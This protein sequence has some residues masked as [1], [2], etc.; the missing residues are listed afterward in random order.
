MTFLSGSGPDSG[1]PRRDI[2]PYI[3]IRGRYVIQMLLCAGFCLG[4][5]VAHLQFER[6]GANKDTHAKIE[7][8]IMF[9]RISLSGLGGIEID[10]WFGSPGSD[11][12]PTP[13]SGPQG[14]ERKFDLGPGLGPERT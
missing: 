4:Q 5:L 12:A 7:M 9:V 11:L 6:G 2:N 14:R 8:R 3:H 1:S 13:G 10:C